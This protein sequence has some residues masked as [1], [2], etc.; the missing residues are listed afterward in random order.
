[1]VFPSGKRLGCPEDNG[2]KK[3]EGDIEKIGNWF[4]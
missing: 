2:S 3:R 1:M 4:P